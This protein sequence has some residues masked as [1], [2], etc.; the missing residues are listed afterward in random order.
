M[1]R[2]AFSLRH[3][4][5]QEVD[6][7]AGSVVGESSIHDS[8]FPLARTHAVS[9]LRDGDAVEVGKSPLRCLSSVRKLEIKDQ[10]HF[11]K[12]S[13]IAAMKRLCVA[14]LLFSCIALNAQQPT[15]T[16]LVIVCECDDL[17]SRIFE[18]KIRDAVAGSPRYYEIRP[19]RDDKTYY[20]RLVLVA[21]DDT[22]QSVVM[23]VVVLRG[24][25]FM[26]S[27]VRACGKNNLDWCANS[28]LSIADHAISEAKK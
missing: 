22:P 23:S 16:P 17:N 24:D 5:T 8:K 20:H 10:I 21:L 18:S 1:I 27:S 12:K 14:C 9:N 6:R 19:G 25:I 11:D 7:K 26:T 2:L 13:I 3:G 4:R 28:V 15:K